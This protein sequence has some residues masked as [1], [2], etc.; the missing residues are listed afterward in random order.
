MVPDGVIP[1]EFHH[2][3]NLN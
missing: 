3:K 1:V 2:I